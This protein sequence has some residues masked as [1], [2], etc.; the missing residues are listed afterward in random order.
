MFYGYNP[1]YF[2]AF[3]SPVLYSFED[4]FTKLYREL[5][6]GTGSW[7]F[8]LVDGMGASADLAWPHI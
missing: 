4:S 6:A 5:Q 7:V 3:L 1:S 2:V 8:M